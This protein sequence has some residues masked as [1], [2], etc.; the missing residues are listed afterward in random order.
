VELPDKKK[1]KYLEQI[2]A[3]NHKSAH[4]LKETEIIIG[5][6][7]HVCLV[8]PDGH[9]H[10]VLLY[11]FRG[12]FKNDHSGRV[13]HRISAA[14]TDDILWWTNRL[15]DKFVGIKIISPPI[16]LNNKLF[17]D[18]STGWGIGLF[19]DGRWLAWQFRDGWKSDER[20]IGWAEMV[21]IKLAIW[22]LVTG[23]LPSAT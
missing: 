18:A 20:E 23:N 14:V 2:S 3:W 22:T 15:Q 12:G 19:L 10:L 9:S 21:A 5:M 16:T 4:T 13:K 8:V 6:L 7:N 11:K 17:V 1:T